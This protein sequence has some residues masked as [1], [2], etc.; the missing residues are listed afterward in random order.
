M[1]LI[2]FL[3]ISIS[4]QAQAFSTTYVN[5]KVDS[6]AYK[7]CLERGH[8]I[9]YSTTTNMLGYSVIEDLPDKTIR[10]V[11]N[12]NYKEYRCS[13]CNDIIIEY[14]Q[15]EPDTLIIWEKK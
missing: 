12:P 3:L 14:I 8:I 5:D 7:I 6:V 9:E 10:V 4:I 2:A 11:Y 13:R 15:P 1:K